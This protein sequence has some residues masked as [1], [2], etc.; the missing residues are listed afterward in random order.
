[1]DERFG[2]N[3]NVMAAFDCLSPESLLNR[4]PL[5]NKA[6]LEQIFKEY[7]PNGSADIKREVFHEYALF[8]ERFKEYGGINIAMRKRISVRRR[9]EESLNG[10]YSK[11]NVQA[12]SICLSFYTLQ[13][14]T[15]CTQICTSCTKS[16]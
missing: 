10:K 5:Q 1:M 8:Q 6:N 11:E 4:S 7:G 15:K 12:H 3:R 13:S 9:R 14:C 16:S 2:K